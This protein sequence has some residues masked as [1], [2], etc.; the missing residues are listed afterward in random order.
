MYH[1]HQSSW[2]ACMHNKRTQQ[3]NEAGQQVR[4][5][6]QNTEISDSSIKAAGTPAGTIRG[7]NSTMKL[8]SR[9]LHAAK[10]EESTTA[11]SKQLARLHAQDNNINIQI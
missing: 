10:T 8:V 4:A 3:H 2:H 7:H 9:Y 1:H 6:R 11:A 5:R